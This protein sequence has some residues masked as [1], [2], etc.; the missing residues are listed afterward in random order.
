MNQKHVVESAIET[1]HQTQCCQEDEEEKIHV[2][3]C[4]V[5]V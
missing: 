3:G 2:S 5:H 1:F 4:M